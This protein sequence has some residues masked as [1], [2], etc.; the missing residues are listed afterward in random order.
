MAY[1]FCIV[2]II[3]ISLPL[4]A[5]AYLSIVTQYPV[6][7]SLSFVNIKQSFELGVGS[8]LLNSLTIALVTSIVGVIVIYVTAYLTARSEKTF[9]TMILHLI[10]MVSL[11]IPGI[12]LGLSYV[13]FFEGSFIYGTLMILVLVNM[14]HFFAS[15][16]L[17]AYNSLG[18]FNEKLEDV[19]AVMGVS[20]VRML[21]D[22]YVPCTRESIVEM[23]SYLFVNS[24]VTISAVSFLANFKNMPLALMIPQFDAQS[25]IEATAFISIIILIVNGILKVGI[26]FMKRHMRKQ[27][28]A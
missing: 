2:V 15:P 16:Y 12:V 10:S 11:A 14:I 20:R 13:I 5:F 17:I 23:F 18:K 4:F 3:L 24:M 1:L 6:D 26:Y 19:A 7:M 27:D 28:V 21:L 25:L 22:V 9:S 8:Y